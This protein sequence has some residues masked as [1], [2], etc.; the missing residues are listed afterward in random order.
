MSLALPNPHQRL[1]AQTLRVTTDSLI[2]EGDELAP[3][4]NLTLQLLAISGMSPAEQRIIQE[5]LEGMI[6][7]H[8]AERWSSKTKS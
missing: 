3:E 8:E 6:I 2:F 1:F 4:V 7:K 5:L